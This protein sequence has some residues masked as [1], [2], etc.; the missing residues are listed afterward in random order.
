M[1]T[2]LIGIVAL[3]L[4][5]GLASG[6]AHAQQTFT[7][8]GTYTGNGGTGFGGNIGN[9]SLT[10]AY[11]AGTQ[12]IDATLNTI[13][14]LGGNALVLYID[15]NVSTGIGSNTS[16]LTD[17]GIPAGTDGGRTAISGFSTNGRTQVNFATGFD[18]LYGITVEPG[19]SGLFNLST[20]SNFGFV[21]SNNVVN[22]N[23]TFTFSFTL[24][25]IGL[26]PALSNNIDFVGTYISTT[27]FRA[28]E[29]IGASVTNPAG[30]GGFTGTQT[31]SAFNRLTTFAPVVVPEAGTLAL[32]ITGLSVIGA[33][34]ARR[35][36]A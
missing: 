9:G 34:V 36:A 26:N 12:S 13:G 31:F 30:N 21:A 6:A 35:R 27:A 7:G 22:A 29:T 18:P 17:T 5:T 14:G 2:H 3:A 11:N 10:L 25:S 28:N 4:V 33:V 19:F 16:T 23:P 1:K 15:N 24:A 20:P 8:T 32:A